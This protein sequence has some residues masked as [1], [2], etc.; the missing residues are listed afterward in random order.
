MK[1]Y[2]VELRTGLKFFVTGDVFQTCVNY[3]LD[4]LGHHP[5]LQAYGF[6]IIMI[7]YKNLSKTMI[8]KNIILDKYSFGYR[9]YY[10]T[11]EG[12]NSDIFIDQPHYKRFTKDIRNVA[13]GTFFKWEWCCPV[14]DSLA[15]IH[16]HFP[17]E[18]PEG[19]KRE[20][21]R[22]C[23]YLLKKDPG[24]T[25][26]VNQIAEKVDPIITKEMCLEWI[27]DMKKI[28]AEYEDDNELEVIY[29][30]DYYDRVS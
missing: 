16:C 4:E 22:L 26:Y 1:A 2:E 13:P 17:N 3:I 19:Y 23:K 6:K 10:K 9:V 27:A 21:W 7:E 18:E 15:N 28:L 12:I 30:E 5:I 11:T 20:L 8:E 14:L 24:F 29:S 25:C